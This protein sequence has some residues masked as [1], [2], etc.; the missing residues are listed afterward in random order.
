M[1]MYATSFIIK[2]FIVTKLEIKY[3]SKKEWIIISVYHIVNYA[4]IYQILYSG[5]LTNNVNSIDLIICLALMIMSVMLLYI[6]S[7]F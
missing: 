3:I 7:V 4:V 5:V 2:K 6:T 1:I